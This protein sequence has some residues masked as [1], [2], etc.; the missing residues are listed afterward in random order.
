MGGSYLNYT[1][2]KDGQGRPPQPEGVRGKEEKIDSSCEVYATHP[3]GAAL[4][5]GAE[6]GVHEHDV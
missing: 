4:P 6:G 3:M 5:G 1:C 2:W